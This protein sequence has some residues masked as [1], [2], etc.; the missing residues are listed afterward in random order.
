MKIYACDNTS[1]AKCAPNYQKTPIF[2]QRRRNN[3]KKD[4]ISN[5]DWE[6]IRNFKTTQ[7]RK[8]EEGSIN[9]ALETIR[10]ILNKITGKNYDTL[11]IDIINN[12]EKHI[13]N[14]NNLMLICRSIFEIGSINSFW[15]E[16]YAKL[17][18]I[19]NYRKFV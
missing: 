4:E 2:K 3:Y 9:A 13:N 1:V 6:L 16:I 15:S 12:V 19:I 11:K 18:L 10:T 14:K 8:N 7:L 5:K 17:C